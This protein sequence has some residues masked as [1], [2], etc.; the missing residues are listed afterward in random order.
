MALERDPALP[1]LLLQAEAILSDLGWPAGAERSTVLPAGFTAR[2]HTLA[3]TLLADRADAVEHALQALREHEGATHDPELLEAA[4][5]AVR[6]WRWL[7][8]PQAPAPAT[9]E[10][11]LTR[12]LSEGGWVD[13]AVGVLW[14]VG[15]PLQPA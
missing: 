1:P 14:N 12:Q 3:Q 7:H 5:M 8:S 4:T 13:R 9:L 2:L 11:S 15:G 6:L 10:A